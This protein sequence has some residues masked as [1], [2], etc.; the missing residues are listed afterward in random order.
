MGTGGPVHSPGLSTVLWEVPVPAQGLSPPMS[1]MVSS[2]QCSTWSTGGTFCFASRSRAFKSISTDSSGGTDRD[3]T[4]PEQGFGGTAP[5]H[6][7][8]SKG[9]RD[10]SLLAQEHP[11]CQGGGSSIIQL[12]P[13]AAVHPPCRLPPAPCR[14]SPQALL[15]KVVAMPVLPE[16]PVRPIR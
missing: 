7:L 16:R 8:P 3:Q 5:R 13:T 12:P 1:S 14:F 15:M 6:H 9:H 4:Q 2:P 10:S 11:P